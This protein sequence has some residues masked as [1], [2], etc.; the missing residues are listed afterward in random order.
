[1]ESLVQALLDSQ[2]PSNS[3]KATQIYA[4]QTTTGY[5]SETTQTDAAQ[6]SKLYDSKATQTDTLGAPTLNEDCKKIARSGDPPV[7]LPMA[8]QPPRGSRVVQTDITELMPIDPVSD[9]LRVVPRS[10]HKRSPWLQ[11]F[12]S[13]GTLAGGSFTSEHEKT[14]HSD[15]QKPPAVARLRQADPDPNTDNGTIDVKSTIDEAMEKC[16]SVIQQFFYTINN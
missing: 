1:M 4:L 7:Q 8:Q 10:G 12:L 3:S 16:H 14:G 9:S 5:K 15:D 6:I 2:S 11:K 13:K